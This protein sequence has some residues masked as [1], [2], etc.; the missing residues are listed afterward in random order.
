MMLNGQTIVGLHSAAELGKLIEAAAAAGSV[1]D[2]RPA[3]RPR[4]GQ[5]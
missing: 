1:D 5:P 2:H 4:R 3:T